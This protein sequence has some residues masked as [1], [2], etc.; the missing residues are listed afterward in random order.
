MLKVIWLKKYFGCCFVGYWLVMMTEE[1]YRYTVEHGVYGLPEGLSG[2]KDRIRPGDR[3]V[4][5]VVRRGC[6][7]LCQSFTAVL[8]VV[9]EWR[10]SSRPMWP[11]E[12]REGRVLY[13][14]VVNVRVVVEGRVEFENVKGELSRI[15]NSEVGSP[16][17][18]RVYMMRE[19][20]SGFGELI[21]EKL[22]S[23]PRTTGAVE[24]AE[25]SH[26][27]LVNMIED[28]AKWLDLKVKTEYFIDNDK[29]V[30]AVLFKDPGAVPFAVVEVHV[31]G[32]ISDDLLKFIEI[33][34]KYHG[35][36]RLIYV[37]ARDENKIMRAV[38][39]TLHELKDEIIIL[40]AQELKQLH[41]VLKQESIRRLI[42]ELTR[43]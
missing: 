37:I 31:G 34:K 32:R 33:R 3:L 14:W 12:V 40:R 10:E 16:S 4:V 28:I 30:D 26:N 2:L 24:R 5:Y 27:E 18:L 1:N 36:S 41:E 20:P 42:K 8:E 9:G 35:A 17:E 22:R 11:D 7:E 39:E 23:T 25:F 15:L 43:K 21:E 38:Q 19:L 6:S 29:K 13:P